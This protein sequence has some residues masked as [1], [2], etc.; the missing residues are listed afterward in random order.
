MTCIVAIISLMGVYLNVRGK[1]QG[2]LFWLASHVGC[3][4]SHH[5]TLFLFYM[6]AQAS[7][8]FGV[9]SAIKIVPKSV[10]FA[11]TLLDGRKFP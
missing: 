2:F 10:L 11:F 9:Q 7:V 6:L 4:F 3:V 5:L 8:K 1:W